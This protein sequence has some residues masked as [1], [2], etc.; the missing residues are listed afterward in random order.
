[1]V[2]IDDPKS[3][4][5]L[6]VVPLHISGAARPIDKEEL[7]P[8]ISSIQDKPI[9]YAV[10]ASSASASAA[11]DAAAK[12]FTS[13][14]KTSPTYRR[15]LLL[16]AAEVLQRRAEDIKEAQ[17]VET[18]CPKE[19]AQFNIHT[20]IVYVKEIAVATSEIRGTVPQR[21]TGPDGNELE[22]LTVVVREPV[23]VVLIIP[24][25]SSLTM[26][27]FVKLSKTQPGTEQLSFP[28]EP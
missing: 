27:D 23:G 28:Y 3:P 12:A 26:M 7:F 15:G 21:T 1:M 11:C 8:V 18:S 6:P 24:R 20:A 13:W 16:K 25:E 4:D 17:M 9:H 14:K 10:S 2:F 19:F 5:G 22:G